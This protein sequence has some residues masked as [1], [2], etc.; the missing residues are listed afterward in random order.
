MPKTSLLKNKSGQ[1]QELNFPG[2]IAAFSRRQDGNMSLRY[3]QT[4]DSL[5]NRKNFLQKLGIDY[6][7]LVCAQQ[8]HGNRAQCVSRQDIGKGA[9][10]Y[11]TAIDDTDAL[12]TKE[13]DLPLAIFTAD[14]LS[15]FLYDPQAPAVGVVH[16]GWRSTQG[17][18]IQETIQ[19]M[20]K[21]FSTLPEDLRVNFGPS[22]GQCCYEVKEEFKN[23]FSFGLRELNG[24]WYLDLAGINERQAQEAGV[25]ENNITGLPLCTS[26]A[27]KD[28]F[29]FRLE[30]DLSG[31]MLSVIMLK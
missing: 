28:F 11:A 18:I 25:K 24:H 14:C 27:N 26:C 8:T 7:S 13:K 22:L 9:L 3:G 16:A 19:A 10:S 30:G 23:F 29:S 17:N 20:Q 21:H 15:A 31:R 5:N 12:V 4:R 6:R 1:W 2:V